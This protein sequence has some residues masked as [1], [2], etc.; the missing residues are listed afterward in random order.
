MD[1]GNHSSSQYAETSSEGVANITGRTRPAK[2]VV[3]R[4]IWIG[5]LTSEADIEVV[6]WVTQT[7]AR[8]SVGLAIRVGVS[9]IRNNARASR[10]NI[11]RITADAVSK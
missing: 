2:H 11:T 3:G 10:R 5:D 6:S 9:R 4:T 1:M 7:A 8:T